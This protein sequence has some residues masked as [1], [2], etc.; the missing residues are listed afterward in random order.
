ML[1]HW[2]DGTRTPAALKLLWRVQWKMTSQMTLSAS[3]FFVLP[4]EL[5][6]DLIFMYCSLDYFLSNILITIYKYKV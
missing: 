2:N 1:Y 5:F 4:A 6:H 3:T